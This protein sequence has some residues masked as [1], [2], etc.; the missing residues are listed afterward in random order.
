MIEAEEAEEGMKMQREGVWQRD[1]EP[2]E[3]DRE[4]EK[5]TPVWAC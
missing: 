5:K 1:T 4:R 2:R 3:R